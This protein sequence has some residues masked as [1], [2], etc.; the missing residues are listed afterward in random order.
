MDK[1]E[2]TKIID[3]CYDAT[4]ESLVGPPLGKNGENVFVINHIPYEV[5]KML[6]A[7]ELPHKHESSNTMKGS[8]EVKEPGDDW[9]KNE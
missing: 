2:L 6:L 3:K 1:Q 9:K 8:M 5:F 4:C 7:S